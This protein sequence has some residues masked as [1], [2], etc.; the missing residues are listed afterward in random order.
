MTDFHLTSPEPLVPIAAEAVEEI[1]EALIATRERGGVG[2]IGLDL[3][4]GAT[5]PARELEALAEEYGCLVSGHYIGDDE[6]GGGYFLFERRDGP[7]VVDGGW[8]TKRDVEPAIDLP[9]YRGMA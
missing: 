5:N 7:N 1:R 3:V 9:S 8:L 4:R 2:G 6:N